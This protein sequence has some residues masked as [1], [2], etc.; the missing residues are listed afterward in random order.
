VVTTV[1]PST[2]LPDPM[3][4]VWSYFPYEER[5]DDPGPAP[6]PALVF[7]W[8]K[9]AS[10]LFTIRVAFGSSKPR[11]KGPHYTV[12]NYNAMMLAGLNKVT[13]FDLGRVADLPW[14]SDWFV[15]PNPKKF[16]TPVIGYLQESS[17]DALRRVLRRRQALGLPTP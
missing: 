9:H 8:K 1:Y 14:D 11:T 6:H 2:T 12:Q 5:P 3:D 4:V 16:S 10:G 17:H 15:S 13:T 7:D